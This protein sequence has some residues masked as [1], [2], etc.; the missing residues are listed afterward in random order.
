M[1]TA[2]ISVGVCAAA[3]LLT[4]PR[5][6]SA[7]FMHARWQTGRMACS[8]G[9]QSTAVAGGRAPTA[10]APVAP[11]A[12]LELKN[13]LRTLCADKSEVDR[14]ARIEQLAKVNAHV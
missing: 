14:E 3:C 5:E 6:A 1:R 8:T 7:F 10:D 12:A 9:R 4:L 11:D 13:K 2:L